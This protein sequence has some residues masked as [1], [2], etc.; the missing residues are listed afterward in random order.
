MIYRK[1]RYLYR[2]GTLFSAKSSGIP[3]FFEPRPISPQRALS[4]DDLLMVYRKLRY[5][6]RQ[7]SLFRTKSTILTVTLEQIQ[8]SRKRILSKRDVMIAY[9]KMRYLIYRGTLFHKKM[10]REELLQLLQ[11]PVTI[12]GNQVKSGLLS[13]R[14]SYRKI[15][16]LIST[17]RLFKRKVI[18]KVKV[19]RGQ[20]LR[21]IRYL[22]TTGG[23]FVIK[24]NIFKDF[25]YNNM[26]DLMQKDYLKIFLNS[27]LLFLLAHIVIFLASNF[28]TTF[29]ASSFNIK[30]IIY[31]SQVDYLIRSDDWKR[32][33]IIAVFSIGPIIALLISVTSLF[34]FLRFGDKKGLV[35]L[36]L[37]WLFFI[38]FI[39][40]VGGISVGVLL[41]KGLGFVMR[42]SRVPDA[43][44]LLLVYAS[45]FT[46][47]L[48]GLL[49]ARNFLLTGN[50]YFDEIGRLNRKSFLLSQ[51]LFPTLVGTA[52]LVAFSTPVISKFNW[53]G[54]SINISALLVIIPV[55]LKCSQTNVTFLTNETRRIRVHWN[56]MIPGL[57]VLVIV[58]FIFSNGVRIN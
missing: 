22:I 36:F 7:G 28:A 58:H 14:T 34:L 24:R 4:I 42:W 37:L 2:Q 1:I 12:V 33:A 32:D 52:I 44:I 18:Y 9:R 57:V 35:N 8:S 5:L 46:L 38:G 20:S 54:L 43:V 30:S 6:Y 27:T 26:Q 29:M 45:I 15:R 51:F 53:S 55:I 31:N 25:W 3:L 21:K 16:F 41:S 39:H 48:S 50:M 13:L 49:L 19:K 17:G 10:T 56:V 23:L 47:I 11:L 40:F